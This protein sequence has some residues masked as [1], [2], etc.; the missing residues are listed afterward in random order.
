MCGLVGIAAK[1]L[2]RQQIKAF[3]IMVHLDTIRGWDSTGV[4]LVS[5][6]KHHTTVD[7]IFTHKRAITGT[8]FLATRTWD[9]MADTAFNYGTVLF[10]HNRAATKGAVCDMNAHPFQHSNITLMHNGSLDTWRTLGGVNNFTVD[11]EAI[12]WALSE[13]KTYE[14]MDDVIQQINGAFSLVFHDTDDNTLHFV[15][16]EERPMWYAD[17]LGYSA[18]NQPRNV[19]GVIWASEPEFIVIAARKANL[20]ITDPVSLKVGTH[21]R[22]DCDT[23]Q[24]LDTTQL[25][26]HVPKKYR[27]GT[28]TTSTKQQTKTTRTGPTKTGNATSTSTSPSKRGVDYK[29]R[30]PDVGEYFEFDVHPNDFTPYTISSGPNKQPQASDN[31]GY[32]QALGESEGFIFRITIH[33]VRLDELEEGVFR[34]KCTAKNRRESGTANMSNWLIIG[35]WN[36]TASLGADTEAAIFDS[37]LPESKTA[38]RAAEEVDGLDAAAAA[39]AAVGDDDVKKLPAPTTIQ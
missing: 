14:E 37:T 23:Q 5:S 28:S 22:M 26:V 3:E 30:V 4:G 12:C 29:K 25:K 15:R 27:G 2:T 31:L 13:A 9:K 1:T 18:P 8:D 35:N 24:V 36:T 19:L 33:Q 17:V 7:P 6:T 10:G 34:A 16:N 11:S 39:I 20:T 21:V 38:E 32:L